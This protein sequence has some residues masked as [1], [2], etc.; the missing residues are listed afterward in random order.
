[1][2]E[3]IRR[4]AT[5]APTRKR[6]N[7]R[8]KS[9]SIS[10]ARTGV[11]EV[12]PNERKPRRRK[13]PSNKKFSLKQWLILAVV[14]LF[15]LFTVGTIAGYIAVRR[16][17][18]SDGFRHLV[19]D[20]VAGTISAEAV[21]MGGFDW[22]GLSMTSS[23]MT[24]DGGTGGKF[25]QI[26]LNQ[27]ETEVS[28][29]GIDRGV[30]E[31]PQVKVAYAKLDL[32]A[33]QVDGGSE[34][35]T[36]ND[37]SGEVAPV[38]AGAVAGEKPG[39]FESKIPRKVEVGEVLVRDANL[40]FALGSGREARVLGAG[41]EAKRLTNDEGFNVQVRGGQVSFLP[42]FGE[43]GNA[44]AMAINSGSVEVRG[45]NLSVNQLILTGV[46]HSARA[47]IDGQVSIAGGLQ[48]MRITTAVA[49]LPIAELLGAKWADRLVGR[50]NGEIITEKKS[51]DQ[52]VITHGE[53]WL[54]DARF[55]TPR[56]P[57]DESVLGQIDGLAA[58]AG[59]GD[60][61]G[62]VVPILGAYTESRARFSSILF[63]KAR[64]RFARR[65]EHLHLRGIEL[66]S[67]RLLAIE[68]DVNL[69][70]ESIDGVLD[71]GVDPSV[72]SRVPGAESQVFTEVKGGMR[73]TQVRVSGTLDDPQ[74]DLSGRLISAAGGRILEVIPETGKAV[75]KGTQQV[76]ENVAPEL[77]KSGEGLLLD[78][79][80]L[81][82]RGES[83]LFK[84]LDRSGR[85][86]A[87]D[88]SDDAPIE[89]EDDPSTN[90]DSG[91]ADD[92]ARGSLIPFL[93]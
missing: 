21:E 84:F 86:D 13:R 35:P 42:F 9:K 32:M 8:T 53:V 71:V 16:Y 27:L 83:S 20:Q 77:I 25:N 2:S 89:D 44:G 22:S 69:V 17:L 3:H 78:G 15:V 75:I 51:A 92:A 62:G 79:A 64:F 88:P 60:L 74:E 14:G 72:L 4:P 57:K 76:I 18:H 58:R 23:G 34:A 29:A 43:S 37:A 82:E 31:I 45:T 41:L 39:W 47:T 1:M 87:V 33:S 55:D 12:D 6:G 80:G 59:L 36:E 81:L 73:W 56:E 26:E 7:R 66:R 61:F 5:S 24:A 46:D 40:R 28:L 91:G 19:E 30:W 63:N 10:P 11:D 52:D 50:F 38:G 49:D 93:N 67:N 54:S 85:D 68:G 70:G 65:G 90:D 48:N